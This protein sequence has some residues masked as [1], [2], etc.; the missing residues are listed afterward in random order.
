MGVLLGVAMD[1]ATAVPRAA[2]DVA[3]DKYLIEHA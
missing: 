2:I 1:L 3:N